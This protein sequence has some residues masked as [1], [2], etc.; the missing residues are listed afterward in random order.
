MR[1]T[2]IQLNDKDKESLKEILRQASWKWC[3]TQKITDRYLNVYFLEERTENKVNL[4]FRLSVG[5]K[6]ENDK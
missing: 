5:N 2:K 1:D 4:V 6:K 3:K